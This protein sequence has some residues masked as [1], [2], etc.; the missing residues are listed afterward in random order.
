M[1]ANGS[2]SKFVWYDQMSNDLKESE[3]F[4][5]AVIGWSIGANTMNAAQY[6]ILQ[7]G[8][9]MIGGL[10][11]I[12]DDAKAMG[13]KPA[14]MGYIGVDDVD[15]YAGKVKAAGGKIY[16]EPSDIPDVGRF[17]VA[18]DPTGAGFILFKGQGEA[19]PPTDPSKPGHIGWRELHAGDG[20]A[21]FDFYAGLFG[22]GRG[23][24]MDMGPEGIYRI[25]MIEGAM[26]GGIMTK[27]PQ[28][29]APHWVYYI[30][31]E[32]ADSAAARVKSAGG[33]ILVG[34][35]QVPGGQWMV[36]AF[37]PQGA[38]FGMLAPRR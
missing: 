15:T 38:L 33:E 21:A 3:T 16:R 10:M 37:D 13:V 30:T 32:A 1:R 23:D 35:L 11:P 24:A 4:Y 18:A 25:F 5:K 12:P 8:D 7:M 9:A 34:P 6:S 2:T 17:A 27:R 20:A 14:W 19:P 29:P 22:W 36:Q 26:A 28:E 31:V